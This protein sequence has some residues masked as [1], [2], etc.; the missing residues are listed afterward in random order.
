MPQERRLSRFLWRFFRQGGQKP[1][2]RRF[3]GDALVLAAWGAAA[4]A[5]AEGGLVQNC[6]LMVKLP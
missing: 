6:R 5:L 2:P 1:C 4:C 3:R